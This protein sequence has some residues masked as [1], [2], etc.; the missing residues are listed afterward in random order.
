LDYIKL[1]PFKI[2]RKIIKF[3]YELYLLVKMKIHLVQYIVILKPVYGNY[4]LPL[5]KVDIYREQEEDK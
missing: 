3:N 2:L 4:E 5:Y 1:G